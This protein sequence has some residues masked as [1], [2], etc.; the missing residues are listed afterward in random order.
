VVVRSKGPT[1][2]IVDEAFKSHEMWAVLAST[3]GLI[4][5]AVILALFFALSLLSGS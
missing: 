2:T 3:V 5:L 4:L 1:A